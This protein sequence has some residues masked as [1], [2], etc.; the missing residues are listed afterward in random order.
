M[1]RN[2]LHKPLQSI[3]TLFNHFIREPIRKDLLSAG[4]L[5]LAGNRLLFQEEEGY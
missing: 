2:N 3:S 5:C 1:S 4:Y